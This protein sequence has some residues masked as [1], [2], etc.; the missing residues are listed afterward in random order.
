MK[1]LTLEEIRELPLEEYLE[2]VKSGEIETKTY[3]SVKEWIESHN[4]VKSD[5]RS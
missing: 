3:N 4:I 5:R 1:K 2:K